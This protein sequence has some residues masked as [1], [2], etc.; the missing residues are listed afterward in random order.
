MSVGKKSGYCFNIGSQR[1]Y[2]SRARATRDGRSED[3]SLIYASFVG[4]SA[5]FSS[6]TNSL[7]LHRLD[8][9]LGSIV[10]FVAN[11]LIALTNG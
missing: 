9:V 5:S 8:I 7:N 11:C 4:W 10:P 3:I 6:A 2:N 1:R